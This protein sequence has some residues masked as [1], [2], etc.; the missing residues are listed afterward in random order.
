MAKFFKAALQGLRKFFFPPATAPATVRVMPYA[1]MGV[2]TVC[3]LVAGAYTWDYT[4]SSVFCGTT[5]HTM[6]P[7]YKA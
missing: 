7:E 4:N 1:T 3:V 5:C 2:L 6:P